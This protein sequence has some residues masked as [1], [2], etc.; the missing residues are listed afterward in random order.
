MEEEVNIAKIELERLREDWV[1]YAL[2]KTSDA[3]IHQVTWCRI[4]R[5]VHLIAG[6]QC[7]EAYLMEEEINIVK[8]ELERL[9]ED[10]VS[11]F[12]DRP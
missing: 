6:R 2:L 4:Q 5:A 3:M 1:S 9:R 11:Y 7:L 12:L 8:I 10:W